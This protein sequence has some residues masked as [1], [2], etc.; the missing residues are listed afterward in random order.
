MVIGRG[1]RSYVAKGLTHAI[2]ADGRR[3]Q[4]YR[5]VQ[6]ELNSIP[7]AN[8]SARCLLGSSEVLVVVKAELSEPEEAV[9][10]QGIVRCS[11][12]CSASA[13]SSFQGYEGRALGGELAAALQ[14]ILVG[15]PATAGAGA[16]V[17][18]QALSIVAG[19]RCWKLHVD[20]LVINADGSLLDAVSIA[21]KAALVDLRIPQV[22]ISPTDD[23]TEAPEIELDDDPEHSTALD[24]S[25]VPLVVSLSTALEGGPIAVDL[26]GQEEAACEGAVLQVGVTAQGQV[27]SLQKRGAAALQ[28]STLQDM[29]STAQQLGPKLACAVAAQCTAQQA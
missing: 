20:A 27:R 16:A 14:R 10:D 18:L 11:V 24:T 17:D 21:T 6:L 3:C 2:R 5:L 26:T 9:P 29:L 4:Q 12:E 15:S 23:P 25:R 28:L 19:S 8:G 1:E 22:Q 7:Q 13:S